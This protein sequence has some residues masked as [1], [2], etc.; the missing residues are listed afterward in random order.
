M[1]V[2]AEDGIETFS[3]WY[4]SEKAKI[5]SRA[6]H[7][8]GG[9]FQEFI[10][11]FRSWAASHHIAAE[12]ELT[13][14]AIVKLNEI[15]PNPSEDALRELS[16]VALTAKNRSETISAKSDFYP[17][18]TTVVAAGAAALS[19]GLP[20]PFKVVLAIFAFILVAASAVIRMKTR[21]Q[22]SHLREMANLIDHFV[23]L[24]SA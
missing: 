1:C 15:F 10:N 20:N 23:K 4:K 9:F 12:T 8:A 22:A 21:E 17:I 24:A 11:P 5:W 3:A 6:Y 18:Y 14:K 16:S 19:F 2:R 13:G 7:N